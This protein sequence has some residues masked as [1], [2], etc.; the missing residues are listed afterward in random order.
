MKRAA[1]SRGPN[2]AVRSRAARS[3]LGDVFLSHAA[4]ARFSQTWQRRLGVWAMAGSLSLLAAG[5]TSTAQLESLDLQIR[6]L[7]QQVTELRERGS[8]TDGDL[9]TIEQNQSQR[10]QE[11][12]AASAEL[13]QRLAEIAEEL[14][15]VT[16]RLTSTQASVADLADEILVSRAEVEQ[17]RSTW[18]DL[19]PTPTSIDTS[20]PVALY[21]AAYSDFQRGDYALALLGFRR[22]VDRFP[23]DER[24]D[25]AQYWIGECYF[26][27]GSYRDAIRE[28]ANVESRYPESARLPTVLYRK[29]LAYIELGDSA[30]GRETLSRVVD[31]YPRS[32]EAVLAQQQLTHLGSS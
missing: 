10:H 26:L 19:E 28:Y 17:L 11:L 16:S 29:G 18:L 24:A 7:Q 5:C 6:Q 14:R 8:E 32:D 20:D 12:T 2:R 1:R 27:Q 22:L 30:S 23:A 4:L 31:E 21:Q 15:A 3:R 13:S 9:A 25:D